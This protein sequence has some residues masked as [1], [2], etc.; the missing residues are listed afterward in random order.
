MRDEDK[1]GDTL[2]S[3]PTSTVFT[4]N[5]TS[6]V[7]SSCAARNRHSTMLMGVEQKNAPSLGWWLFLQF[8]MLLSCARAWYLYAQV[9]RQIKCHIWAQFLA[10]YQSFASFSVQ[11][12]AFL[13]KKHKLKTD[14][15]M[16]YH[17]NGSSFEAFRPALQENGKNVI[18]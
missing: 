6:D 3:I 12:D 5:F 18:A 4:L 16:N 15:Y 13:L 1:K 9:L 7:L 2:D 14:L 11:P 8:C 10:L 17:E